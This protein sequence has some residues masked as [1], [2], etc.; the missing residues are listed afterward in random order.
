MLGPA[1]DEERALLTE[2]SES[3]TVAVARP[4]R[5][6]ATRPFR[7]QGTEVLSPSVK[8]FLLAKSV[9]NNK[10]VGDLNDVTLNDNGVAAV[11]AFSD[12]VGMKDDFLFYEWFRNGKRVAKVRVGVWAKRW[13][14]YSSKVLNERMRGSW[15]I[16]LRND[17]DRLLASAD[18]LF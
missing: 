7:L 5:G 8:R 12:V 13:R 3:T 15:R 9:A 6:G 16:E 10:P 1:K 4:D 2:P 11:Y 14:S 18:F 17:E